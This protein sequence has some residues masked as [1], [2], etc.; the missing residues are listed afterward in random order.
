MSV[1][2]GLGR[3]ETAV[4]RRR[5]KIVAT[6]GPATDDEVVLGAMFRAGVDVV[7][8]NL[9]HGHLE[10]HVQRV[11]AVRRVAA[12]QGRVVAVL[13]DLPGPKI[14]ARP[15]P[16]GGVEFVAGAT[17]YLAADAGGS[18]VD[19]VRLDDATLLA[20][21]LPGDRVVLGDGAISLTVIRRDDR[22]EARVDTGGRTQGSPGVHL[23]SQRVHLATPTDDD[24]V[25]AEAMA[26]AG[27]DF[28]AV[29]FVR[30]AADLEPVRRVAGGRSRLVA[31][32]ETSAALD[33]LDALVASA[34]AIMVA[35]GDLG[36]DCRIE[37]VPHLQKRIVR[38]CV[39][40]GTPVIVATQ[41]LES[42]VTA[43]SPTR[44]EVSDVANAVF[45]GADALM[46]S[47]ETA[48]GRDPVAVV[49]TMSRVAERAERD[50]DYRQ[51]A[52]LMGRRQRDR[53]ERDGD[54]VTD[55]VCHAA[56][57]A[58]RDLEVA[59]VLCCTRSGATARAMARFRPDA[60]LVGLS[61]SPEVVRTLALSWGVV[62][63]QVGTYLSTD[64]LVWHAVE[65]AVASGLATRGDTVIVLAGA[66]DRPAP[67][68]TDV[69]RVVA[70][71]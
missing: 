26:A 51:W 13:A 36:I 53:W 30:T 8:L 29:S 43:P 56:S 71:D 52:E 58:A 21:L 32:I 10:D 33:D 27:A 49:A 16:D 40:R 59:A 48:I 42:M 44:A 22:C 54:R 37:D 5:T 50:A 12:A 66:P 39:Q 1:T 64:D 31:K 34:D 28:L 55:A 23:S 4:M 25:L 61:P 70:V 7:R 45:D 3:C 11:A 69:L 20:G 6:L 17:V 2:L 57:R 38:A 67:A 47:G 14:R 60:A 68:T 9:S 62:P 46:L 19:V 24:L 65:S 35:R 41:M 18:D 63:V 15:F